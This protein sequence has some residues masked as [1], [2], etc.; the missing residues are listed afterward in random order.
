VI[1]NLPRARTASPL[2]VCVVTKKVQE[3]WLVVPKP[4][5]LMCLEILR[6]NNPEMTVKDLVINNPTVEG[7]G[8][9]NPKLVDQIVV[10]DASVEDGYTAIEE[11]IE[12]VTVPT[13]TYKVVFK[14]L[15]RD[16]P[17]NVMGIV[18]LLIQL[19]KLRPVTI[20]H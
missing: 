12:E 11:Y 7:R 9:Y 4:E 1:G 18:K 5:T 16:I 3:K 6:V 14:M 19:G 17:N 8:K 10:H 20:E 13:S 2:D 15:I